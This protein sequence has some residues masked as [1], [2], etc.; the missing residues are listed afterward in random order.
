MEPIRYD[1]AQLKSCLENSDIVGA[2]GRSP[3]DVNRKSDSGELPL[4][5][6]TIIFM[7]MGALQGACTT[8]P[9]TTRNASGGCGLSARP[10]T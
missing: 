3:A 7:R 1:R 4:A 5:P 10:H 2:T 8:V 9:K 6:T